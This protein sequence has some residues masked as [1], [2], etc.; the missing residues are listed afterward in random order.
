MSLSASPTT[1]WEGQASRV[2]A[3]LSNPL[4]YGVLIPVTVTPCPTGSWC[5][6]WNNYGI[7]IPAGRTVG[8]LTG[9]V[10]PSAAHMVTVVVDGGH[11]NN[12]RFHGTKMRLY[13]GPQ[14][15]LLTVRDADAEDEEVTVALG[16]RLPANVRAGSKASQ[17]IKVLD[18]D[19]FAMTLTADKQP[20]EAESGR[21]VTVTLDL[22]RPAPSGFFARLKSTG[23]ANYR[24]TLG[25]HV[26]WTTDPKMQVNKQDE[27]FDRVV[28]LKDWGGKSKRTITLTIRD[29]SEVDPD[30]TIVLQ[31]TGYNFP[32]PVR[33]GALESNEL[34]L[35]IA[36]ND[37]GAAA[38]SRIQMGALDTFT[39]ETGI[40]KDNTAR[41]RVW[42][43]HPADEAVS[44]TYTT[45][46]GT[47]RSNGTVEAGTLDYTAVSGTLTFAAGETLKEIEIPIKDDKVEDSWETF[48]VRLSNPTPSSLV[49]LSDAE[50][51]VTILNDEADLEGL[52][53]WGAPGAGGPFARLD[54]G[55]FD[56]AVSDYA[57]TVPHGT[58][59][60]KLAGI[61]PQNEHLGLKAGRAGSTLTAVRSDVAGPAVPLAVGDTVLVVQSTASTG[62]RKTYRV[63]VTR[64]AQ[65]LS[66]DAD[67]SGLTAEAGADGSWTELDLGAFA[68]GTTEYAATV[69]H[70]TTQVRA[71][72]DGGQRRR[73]AEGGRGREPVRRGKRHGERRPRARC[74]RQCAQG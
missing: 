14:T 9:P 74:G 29:D 66:S 21:T 37:G 69:P 13:A 27:G 71:D 52:K 18:P 36:D 45:A 46:D 73:D 8:N 6:R 35:T 10:N 61:A 65:V 63:T 44:V 11:D 5:K 16:S 72:G 68:A 39:G 17:K 4:P 47:A 20:G 57:V 53:L 19:G 51:T 67:L 56:G 26:D 31:A 7:H 48:L 32:V 49:R 62:E 64:E 33:N 23:T 43:S 25:N 40:K 30:E 22:G 12:G 70:G 60:A 50:A 2:T 3:T 58:T 54:L 55:A 41:V 28:Y 1:V 24:S 42:L 15:S 38:D 34:P 59:H